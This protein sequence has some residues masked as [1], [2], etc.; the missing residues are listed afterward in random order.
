MKAIILTFDKYRPLTEHMLFCYKS[1]WPNHPFQFRI[2][3]QTI[4]YTA[5]ENVISIQTD[6][7]IKAS[8]LTLIK[9]LDDEEWIYWCIDDKYPVSLNVAVLDKMVTAIS[10]GKMNNVDGILFCHKAGTPESS[11]VKEVK[12]QSIEGFHLLPRKKLKPFW[13]HQFIKV[14]IIRRVFEQFPDVIPRAKM[15]DD[16]LNTMSIPD[17]CRLWLTADNLAVFGESTNA[18][19]ITQNCYD[20]ILKNGLTMPDLTLEKGFVSYFGKKPTFLKKLMKK[21]K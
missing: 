5:D 10:S 11:G 13:I 8:V 4:P 14:K 2:P 6:K 9:D 17:G 16:L 21:I 7:A 1:I 19:K 12:P 3:Y 18:G 20:S 15:M